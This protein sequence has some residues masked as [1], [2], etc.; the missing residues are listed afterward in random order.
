MYTTA[1]EHA[2]LHLEENDTLSSRRAEVFDAAQSYHMRLKKSS[3][4]WTYLGTFATDAQKVTNVQR[5]NTWPAMLTYL[6]EGL[7]S[8]SSRLQALL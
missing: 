4:A 3:H 7:Q 2:Y 5:Q 8:S 1:V 6:F